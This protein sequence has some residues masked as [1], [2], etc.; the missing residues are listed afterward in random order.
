MVRVRGYNR[1][2]NSTLP[3]DSSRNKYTS[4]YEYGSYQVHIKHFIHLEQIGA[5]LY[6]E[7]IQNKRPPPLHSSNQFRAVK[8][9]SGSKKSKPPKDYVYILNLNILAI[10]EGG[11]GEE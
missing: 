11:I 10:F 8:G 6:Q 7:Q 2:K 1:D 9:R 4:R 3:K 5:E